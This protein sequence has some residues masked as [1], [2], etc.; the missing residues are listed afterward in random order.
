MDDKMLSEEIKNIAGSS[1]ID[2]IGFTDASEFSDYT[3]KQ[4]KR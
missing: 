2:V 3:L 4:S 1:L